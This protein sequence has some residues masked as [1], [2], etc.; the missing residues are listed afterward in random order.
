MEKN[1]WIRSQDKSILIKA[2]IFYINIDKDKEQEK[3]EYEI[4][5]VAH[6]GCGYVTLGIY[7][8]EKR[9]YEILDRLQD[10]IVDKRIEIIEMPNE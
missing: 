3:A 10:A 7:P 9:A 6:G 8:T 4:R 5:S 2:D 1:L